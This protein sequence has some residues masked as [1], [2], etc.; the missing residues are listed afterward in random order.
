[1]AIV[2][3][4][5]FVVLILNVALI[6]FL[7]AGRQASGTGYWANTVIRADRLEKRL[8]SPGK[9]DL[10]KASD[11]DV[12][13]YFS[14]LSEAARIDDGYTLM[15]RVAAKAEQDEA[16]AASYNEPFVKALLNQAGIATFGCR[17]DDA[18]SI[19]QRIYDYDSMHLKTN[20]KR[21]GRDY[22][23]LGT[24]NY[25]KAAAD[26]DQANRR[27]LYELAKQNCLKAEKLLQSDTSMD[28][29]AALQNLAMINLD[30]GD[31]A[32]YAQFRQQAE[33]LR[34]ELHPLSPAVVI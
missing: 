24:I 13:E 10:N 5:L 6:N 2:L 12:E 14:A 15:Q 31:Q 23:N 32:G 22:N 29:L 4:L 25:L 34:A 33:A 11:K 20:D 17:L 26:T 28:R 19:Y 7:S 8:G 21:I 16:S 3:R 9:I 18:L 27:K 30:L 1:M